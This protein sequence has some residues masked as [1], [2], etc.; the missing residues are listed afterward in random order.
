MLE[1]KNDAYPFKMLEIMLTLDRMI[2]NYYMS[3]EAAKV[4]DILKKVNAIP[5]SSRNIR[6]IKFQLFTNYQLLNDINTGN[7]KDANKIEERMESFYDEFG[8]AISLQ[9]KLIF[10][11]NLAMLFF[12]S[13]NYTKSS[14]WINTLLDNI[15][16]KIDTDIMISARLVN[17][18]LQYEQKMFSLIKYSVLSAKRYIKKIRPLNEFDII[19][20][21]TIVKLSEYNTEEEIRSIIEDFKEK[22]RGIITSGQSYDR[23]F[24]YYQWCESKIEEVLLSKIIWETNVSGKRMPFN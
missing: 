18:I 22:L 17:I 19:F 7:V 4:N 9:K 1:S 21:N 15:N 13:G 14:K 23:C 20:F 10:N 11:F 6:L 16:K 12:V 8:D 5:D 2:W 3:G 24:P